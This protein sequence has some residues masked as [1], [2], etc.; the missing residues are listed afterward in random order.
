MPLSKEITSIS[1][2]RLSIS[3]SFSPVNILH[4]EVKTMDIFDSQKD[5]AIYI[6]A[7]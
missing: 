4:L 1:L 6:F 5:F 2:R 7:L 3:E